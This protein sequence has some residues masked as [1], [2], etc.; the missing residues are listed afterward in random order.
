[1]E[2]SGYLAIAKRWWWTLIVSAWIAGVAG[3]IVAS[4]LPPTYE[5]QTKVLVG[6]INT[7]SDTLRASALLV[8]T[9]AQVVTTDSLLQST[10]KELGYELTADD[11]RTATRATAN[12][13]T[14]IL[15]IRVQSGDPTRAAKLANT[16]ATKLEQLTSQGVSR[17]EGLIQIV[18]FAQPSLAS[19]PVAPQ[20]SLITILAAIAGIVMAIVIVLIVEYFGQAVRTGEELGTLAGAPLLGAVG[21][22]GGDRPRASDLVV[23]GEPNSRAASAYRLAAAKVAFA[24]DGHQRRSFVVTDVDWEGQSAVVATNIA[25]A[26]A[27]LGRAVVLI[28]AAGRGGTV[29]ALHGLTDETGLSEVLTGDVSPTFENDDGPGVQIIPAGREPL[30]V[31]DPSRVQ[32]LIDELLASGRVVVIAVAPVRDEPQSL[33]FARSVDGVV[34]VARTDRTH[35]DDVEF[36]GESMRLIGATVVGVVAAQKGGFLERAR[37]PRD[38]RRERPEPRR[39]ELAP[40]GSVRRR[41][42]ST[43]GS[44]RVTPVVSSRSRRPQSD[45]PNTPE[46]LPT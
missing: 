4:G 24:E 1:M 18:E 15:S 17:P 19:E 35:R 28:D 32:L 34:L 12:D 25:S 38:R 40:P 10:I 41:A 39:V 46:Q 31:V 16:L 7:D 3:Y 20:V 45:G 36:V 21:V 11:L 6:P 29:T 30:D 43:V 5:S 2:L 9:Y 26:L 37:R 42:R 13:V 14:R 8:Q 33:A 44:A 23:D 22:A 27:R